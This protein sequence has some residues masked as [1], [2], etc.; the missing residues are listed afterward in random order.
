MIEDLDS[1][2]EYAKYSFDET[3]KVRKYANVDIGNNVKSY[4]LQSSPW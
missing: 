3:E 4:Q 1:I 2:G